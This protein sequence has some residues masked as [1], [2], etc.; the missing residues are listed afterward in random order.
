MHS[1]T[2]YVIAA[3]ERRGCGLFLTASLV[4]N[5]VKV[6]KGSSVE[7]V[8]IENKLLVKIL[9][10]MLITSLDKDDRRCALIIRPA[11]LK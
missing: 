2:F 8:F 1:I 6:I 11:C 3:E 10:K 5:G 7:Y 9:L 4:M